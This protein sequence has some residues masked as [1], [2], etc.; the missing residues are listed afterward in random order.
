MP[1]ER[2]V[3]FRRVEVGVRG[4]ARRSGGPAGGPALLRASAAAAFAVLAFSATTPAAAIAAAEELDVLADDLQ[5]AAFLAGR[6][7][8]IDPS[9]YGYRE[10][11]A[12][13]ARNKFYSAYRGKHQILENGNILITESEAGHAFEATPDGRIAWSLVNKYD[14]RNVGWLMSATR[15]PMSYAGVGEKCAGK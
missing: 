3:V 5:L 9:T 14:D 15:Y 8:A 12:S 13:D 11:Y 2:D 1:S 6:I 10:I 7:I 4:R